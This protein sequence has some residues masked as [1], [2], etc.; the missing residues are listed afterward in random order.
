[1][2]IF[3]SGT[4]T[5]PTQ[6]IGAHDALSARIGLAAGFDAVWVSS[7]GMSAAAGR[8]DRNELSWTEI[9]DA[10]ERIVEAVDRPVILDGNEGYGDREIAR[11][12]VMRA[13]QR[14]IRGVSLE[15]KTY[16]KK[17]SLS[18]AIELIGTHSFVDKIR[19]CRD[20]IGSTDFVLMGRTDAL[21]AGH[22][23]AHA[24][25]RTEAYAEAGA[26][27]IIVHSV[28]SS[29]REIELFMKQWSG[30]CPVITIPTTFGAADRDTYRRFGFS[31][32][33][34]ANQLI[35]A[36]IVAMR[37]AAEK[38]CADGNTVRIEEQIARLS[39]IFS[40]SEKDWRKPAYGLPARDSS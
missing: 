9:V 1:M 8:R 33:I 34:W 26:D 39:D 24:I 6:I 13:A 3:L 23:I 17:N 37:S 36:A 19:A 38:L 32:L 10:A 35:R 4:S 20:S 27:A 31:G 21:V 2:G 12:L 7:L 18:D 11:L 22:S 14:G 15:D 5:S 16:P 25:D 40:L 29:V 28:S 30:K